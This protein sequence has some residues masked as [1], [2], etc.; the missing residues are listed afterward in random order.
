MNAFT[1]S[2]GTASVYD[3]PNLYIFDVDSI[4]DE[5]VQQCERFSAEKA[6]MEDNDPNEIGNMINSAIGCINKVRTG[7]TQRRNQ[8]RK[9]VQWARN[10]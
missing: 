8:I 9:V 3:F 4:R 7:N 10:I 6:A 1:S 5:L 2:I